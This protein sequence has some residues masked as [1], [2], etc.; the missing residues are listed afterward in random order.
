MNLIGLTQHYLGALIRPDRHAPPHARLLGNAAHKSGLN[1]LHRFWFDEIRIE[2]AYYD[3][4]VPIWFMGADPHFDQDCTQR[5]SHY[6]DE[7]TPNENFLAELDTQEYLALILLFDQIPRNVFRNSKLAYAFDSIAQTLCLDALNSP[8]ETQLSFPERLFL[9]MPLEHAENLELQ[10]LCVTKFIQ[11]HLESP[12]TIKK[13]TQL[14]LEKAL[15][16]RATIRKHGCFPLR[17][18]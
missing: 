8:R 11:L 14:A 6:I 4:K 13:W 10:N 17:A 2:N 16:H 18:Q 3:K 1:A 5:F 9:Y 12:P 15:E 7:I